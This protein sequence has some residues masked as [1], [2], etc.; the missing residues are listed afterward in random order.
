MSEHFIKNIEIKNFKCFK[1]FKA[2][3]FSRVNLVTG[4][5]NVG[6][7]AFIEACHV[8]TCSKD[9]KTI[10]TTLYGLKFRRENINILFNEII[11]DEQKFLE[12]TSGIETDSNIC[13]SSFKIKE[14][15]GV[16][17]YFFAFDNQDI[18]VN[19]NDFS[20]VHQAIKN[21][22][23][24]DNFGMTNKEILYNF[25]SIQT[26]DKESFLN[27]ILNNFDNSIE[28]F[29]NIDE[30][31]QCKI[32]GKYLEITEL[33]D[34]TRHL[35][36]IVVSL[37]RCQNGAL[38]ID[39]L[40]NGIHYS[41]LD[42]LWEV[43]LKT[44]KE[45]NVQVFATTH[46]KECIESY[47]RVAKKLAEKEVSLTQLVKVKSGEIKAGIYNYDVLESAV[48]EQHHEVRG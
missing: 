30:K 45:L 12:Q 15:N 21:N 17:T 14:E 46:S 31:P 2:E 24:I 37:F 34:G 16:K 25:S 23:F 47:A 7:T 43:I 32:N 36:S 1:D 10:S 39:E 42:E 40:E 48:L 8:N 5:N 6:K 13:K 22:E 20:L 18:S 4:K 28:N 19:V 29:K 33:G 38:F 41:K 35:I 26:L 3:G 11:D 44:S 27:K 9:V